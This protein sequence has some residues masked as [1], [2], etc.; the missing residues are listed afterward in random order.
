M[1][2]WGLSQSNSERIT[3]VSGNPFGFKNVLT[4]LEKQD[5]QEVFG[6][7][8]FP[9]TFDTETYPLIM[10]VAGSLGWND[11]HYDYL[12]MY[13]KMGI[14]TFELKSFESRGVKSTVGSQVDVTTAMMVLD[15]YKA[16]KTLEK[17]PKIDITKVGIMGWS[18]GGGVTLFSGWM[19]LKNSIETDL[20]FAAHLAFYPPC[21]VEPKDLLFTESPMHIIIGELDDWTP[22][23]A[24]MELVPKL[25]FAGVQIG[26]TVYDDSHHSFDRIGEV[27]VSE[28]GYSFTDCRLKMGENGAVLM[29]FL[30]IPMTTPLL[31][32]IGLSFCAKRGV[33][34]GGNPDTREKAFEFA[35]KFMK[36]HLLSN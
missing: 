34:Y 27:V 36:Q 3:F 18:L 8:T 20:S 21:F 32:K 23:N 30:N 17:H 25:Q 15:A 31:Q 5:T 7:L 35:R 1:C 11:H 13:R 10:G 33:H 24:C 19:P 4:E 22:A 9:E 16:L 29:N 28:S 14:A 6:I 26:L 2:S 12:N